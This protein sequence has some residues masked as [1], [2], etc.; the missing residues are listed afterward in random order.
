MTEK[1]RK[2]LYW[3]FKLLGILVSCAFP[4]FAICE[5]F[6]IW[7]ETHGASHSAGV[8]AVMIAIVVL[9][10]F[11]RTVFKFIRER[12]DLKHAPPLTVWM[13]LL[14]IVY[15]MIYIGNF[16]RDLTTVLWMGLI[17]CAIGTFLTYLSE[18]VRKEKED[19]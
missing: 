6:P 14:V 19:G 18:R 4:I 12:L 2:T 3:V 17:G 16:L 5:K 7:T 9:I 1:K 10:V 8:G 15:A 11:R 13:V